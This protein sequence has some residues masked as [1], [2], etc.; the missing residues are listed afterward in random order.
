MRRLNRIVTVLLILL[1]MAGIAVAVMILREEQELSAAR[2]QQ[3]SRLSEELQPIEEKRKELQE[4]D[5]EWQELLETEKNGK[6]CI[7]LTFDNTGETL[8]ETMY[9]MMEQYGFRGT[10]IMRDGAFPGAAEESITSEEFLELMDSGWEYAIGISDGS[11]PETESEPGFFA[12]TE[13]Q[14]SGEEIQEEDQE[15]T[16]SED[17]RSFTEQVDSFLAAFEERQWEEPVTLA[18]TRE[19]YGEFTEA[20]LA[21]RGFQTVCILNNEEFPV[22]EEKTGDVWIIESGVFKQKN[23]K[24]EDAIQNAV[25]N[26]KSMAITVNDILKISKNASYD[27]SITKF[28][29]LL[30]FLKNLEEQGEINIITYSEFNQYED[31]LEQA[32]EDLAARYSTFRKDMN[33]QLEELNQKEQEIV[34]SLRITE[35]QE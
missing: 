7:M 22:I 20:E 23:L 8:Y 17:D 34:E 29:S 11:E 31:Q 10:F 27:L 35:A 9:D 30:T 2:Q 19:Q 6:P 16:E 25:Q 3:V 13:S 21:R 28:S 33:Q 14:E 24:V 32:Y 1:S 26:G 15:E 4:K 18:C 5:K 12:E